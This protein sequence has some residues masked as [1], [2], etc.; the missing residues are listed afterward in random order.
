[1]KVFLIF[2]CLCSSVSF[3]NNRDL[4]DCSSGYTT[5]I[6]EREDGF[7]C[8]IDPPECLPRTDRCTRDNSDNQCLR[9][10][11]RDCHPAAGKFKVY[12]YST[13]LSGSSSRRD[14]FASFR[15]Q[16]ILYRG[17]M[18]EYGTYGARIQDPNDPNYEYRRCSERGRS[19]T[20]I[21]Y[22][23][24]SSCTYEQVTDYLRIWKS[25]DFRLCSHNCQDFAR[26]LGTYLTNDC[27]KSSRKRSSPSDDEFAEYIFSISGGE[28]CNTTLDL[29]SSGS[30][31][32]E[33]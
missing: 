9:K 7:Y 16:F 10:T 8:P 14:L 29:S 24:A 15:H 32:Q 2:L 5:P 18:Y 21:K 1:M 6:C 19:I 27:K 3:A 13:P 31:E 11:Y 28:T 17:L 23:G 26:G 4:K 20:D 25:D 33:S 30:A 22:L 12:K